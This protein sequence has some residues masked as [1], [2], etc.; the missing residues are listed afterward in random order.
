LQAFFAELDEIV[1]RVAVTGTG[2]FGSR[3]RPSSMETLQRSA[4][5]SVRATASG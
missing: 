2:Y 1:E 4:I 3:I 5:S